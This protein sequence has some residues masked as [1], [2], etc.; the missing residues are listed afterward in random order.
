MQLENMKLSGRIIT[1]TSCGLVNWQGVQLY[2]CGA[3]PDKGFSEYYYTVEG[4]DKL[5]SSVTLCPACE[6]LRRKDLAKKHLANK[7]ENT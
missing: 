2:G 3:K 5:W 7:Q 6:V 1:N 4:Y